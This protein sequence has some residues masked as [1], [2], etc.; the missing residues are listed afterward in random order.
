[1]YLGIREYNVTSIFLLNDSYTQG[2]DGERLLKANVSKCWLIGQS[3]YLLVECLKS[4]IF[5]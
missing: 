5:I 2:S 1:M 4:E 3:R